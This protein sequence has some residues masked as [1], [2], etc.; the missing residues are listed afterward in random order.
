MDR[1]ER[2][3]PGQERAATRR[4]AAAQTCLAQLLLLTKYQLRPKSAEALLLS[5][6]TLLLPLLQV[7]CL[8]GE[9]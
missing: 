2:P 8:L 6:L 4:V 3:L 7:L 1:R 5:L 9:G